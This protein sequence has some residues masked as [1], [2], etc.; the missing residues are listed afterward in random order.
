MGI[1]KCGRRSP[2]KTMSGDEDMN[3]MKPHKG[4]H[5]GYGSVP[6]S[7]KKKIRAQRRRNREGKS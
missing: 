4:R 2:I 6:G 7:G 5:G 1:R 3:E